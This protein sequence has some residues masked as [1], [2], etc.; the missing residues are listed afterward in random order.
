MSTLG[1]IYK[2]GGTG[3][4][5][6][7]THM[8]PLNELFIEAGFNVRDIDPEHVEEFKQAYINGED[9]PPLYVEAIEPNR[10]K[11]V[12]GH[13]RYLGAKA[14]VADG[15]EIPRL[16]CRDFIGT[17]ADKITFMITTSQGKALSPADRANAYLRLIRQGFTKEEIAKRVKRSITDVNN[18]LDFAECDETLKELVKDGSLSYGTAVQIQ[19]ENGSKAVDV[20]TKAVET[21]KEQGKKRATASI[22]KPKAK[23]PFL[24]KFTLGD[25]V[26]HNDKVYIVEQVQIYLEYPNLVKS[27]D[28]VAAGTVKV[29]YGIISFADNRLDSSSVFED[30][31]SEVVDD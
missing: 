22:V 25:K 1:Q 21:A 9:V 27:I 6:K 10:I 29:M 16:E 20:A 18:H 26:K 4:T 2:N 7:K 12:D 17:E 13:H 19:K 30:E 14:A 3:V 11:I 24:T 8:V 15:Y 31:I 5:V 28:E 23:K